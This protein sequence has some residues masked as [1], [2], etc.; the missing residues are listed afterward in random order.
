MPRRMK[1]VTLGCAAASSNPGNW[2]E[3][4]LCAG[5]KVGVYPNRRK[6]PQARGTTLHF[7]SELGETILLMRGTSGNPF[8]MQALGADER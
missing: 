8:A 1:A 4:K 2:L 7:E 5:S 6:S 3:Q